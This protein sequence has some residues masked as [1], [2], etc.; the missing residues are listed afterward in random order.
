MHLPPAPTPD[1]STIKWCTCRR[2]GTPPQPDQFGLN[3]CL[4]WPMGLYPG[5]WNRML[6]AFAPRALKI[7]AD[8]HVRIDVEFLRLFV[9]YKCWAWRLAHWILPW[10]SELAL[11]SDADN[12]GSKRNEDVSRCPYCFD[13]QFWDLI[14]LIEVWAWKFDRWAPPNTLTFPLRSDADNICVKRA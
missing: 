5:I 2:S 8:F 14:A 11:K 6:T 7:L 12:I 1:Q 13:V 3:F 10:T 9:F 4:I